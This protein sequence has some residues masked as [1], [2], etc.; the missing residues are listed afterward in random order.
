MDNQTPATPRRGFKKVRIENFQDHLDT[1]IKFKP[2]LNLIVGSSDHGK[3]AALRSLNLLLHNLPKGKSFIHL[4]QDEARV[5]AEF[6]D[7]M[8]VERIKGS[9]RNCVLIT[10]GDGTVHDPYEKFGDKYPDA[11]VQALGNPPADSK[12]GPISYADQMAPLFLV[13][14]TETELPR[15]ISELTGIDDFE[16]AAKS[17][18]AEGKVAAKSVKTAEA[19]IERSENQLRQFTGLDERLKRYESLR[20]KGREL[21]LIAQRYERGQALM[22][23][24]WDVMDQG[25]AAN[26]TLQVSRQIAS[27]SPKLNSIKEIAGRKTQGDRFIERRAEHNTQETRAEKALA[28]ASLI[29]CQKNREKMARAFELADRLKGGDALLSNYERLMNEGRDSKRLLEEA[30]SRG[31]EAHEEHGRLLADM[32]AQGLVC[33]ACNRP[34]TED[35]CG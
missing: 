28:H 25:K 33:A 35:N 14:L 29:V 8:I 20:E 16:E 26:A 11:V 9:S 10:E 21:Q 6:S 30:R 2:G 7:G 13:S 31:K 15:I 23:R 17:L 32:I 27:L 12:H 5:Y 22:T 18:A 1:T 34:F 24:Y 4:G 19:Q 3:S